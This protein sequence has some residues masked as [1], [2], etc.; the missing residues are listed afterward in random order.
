MHPLL[1]Y[2]LVERIIQDAKVSGKDI[3][4]TSSSKLIEKNRLDTF[5]SQLLAKIPKE[6][7]RVN[8]A[9]IDSMVYTATN[10]QEIPNYFQKTIKTLIS[11]MVP[12]TDADGQEAAAE[13]SN[14]TQNQLLAALGAHRVYLGN[15]T[16]NQVNKVIEFVKNPANRFQAAKV[17]KELGRENYGGI[18]E[19]SN[20]DSMLVRG[21]RILHK[22][23]QRY[24]EAFADQQ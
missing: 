17:Q 12:K 23:Q 11:G 3:E 14:V 15:L 18:V 21:V 2:Q 8:E 13:K 16:S 20:F 22:F 4:G 19:S 1:I 6:N 10:F 24:P 7:A 5:S 9:F